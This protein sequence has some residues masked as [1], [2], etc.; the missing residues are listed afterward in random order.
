[1]KSLT[2]Y[3]DEHTVLTAANINIPLYE[4]DTNFSQLETLLNSHIYENTNIVIKNQ[5]IKST[6]SNGRCVYFNGTEWDILNPSEYYLNYTRF[7]LGIVSNIK[8]T[9]RG[10]ITCLGI[11]SYLE[12]TEDVQIGVPY[13]LTNNGKG[14]C[15]PHSQAIYLGQFLDSSRFFVNI[16]NWSSNHVHHRM[17]LVKANW[18]DLTTYYLYPL[19]QLP[20]P[21]DGLVLVL[22]GWFMPPATT[23]SVDE[24]GLKITDIGYFQTHLDTVDVYAYLIAHDGEVFWA[25][26]RTPAVTSVQSITP[27][28]PNIILQDRVTDETAT[29]GTLNIKC[30]PVLNNV[31]STKIS[32]KVIKNITINQTTGTLEVE[33]GEYIEKII[34]GNNIA[35]TNNA[36]Q[37]RISA[38]SSGSL[39]FLPSEI[40]LNGSLTKIYSGTINHYIELSHLRQNGI[41]LSFVLPDSVGKTK[42][43][44]LYATCWAGNIGSCALTLKYS[45]ID[46]I[47]NTPITSNITIPFGTNY[48]CDQHLLYNFYPSN[49]FN[50]YIGRSVDTSFS[51]PIGI[52]G[53]FIRTIA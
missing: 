29:I 50:I 7:P 9:H 35:V 52:F 51:Y 12:C 30:I 39:T 14:T 34:A 3:I 26:P 10:D 21:L 15:I 46:Y 49:T 53:F 38:Y 28:T 8:V 13:Y 4:A 6:V 11:L 1:M 22:D 48:K 44:S 42:Q 24:D 43:A 18:Q 19:P 47:T 25:D 17:Q 36:G 20:N 37:V 16:Q 32:D 45:A 41:T 27:R 40:L 23:Y 5:P 2:K 31:S 33:K